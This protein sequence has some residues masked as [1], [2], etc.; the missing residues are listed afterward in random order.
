VLLNRFLEDS[1]AGHPEKTAL[2]CGD[3]RVT[4]AEMNVMAN[5]LA[6]AFRALGLARQDRVCIYHDNS[7]EA[8]MGIFATLKAA[9]IF[10]VVN[11]EVKGDKLSYILNDSGARILV[12]G[13]RN[14]SGVEGD[15]ARTSNLEHIIVAD[16]DCR[17]NLEDSFA[18]V[19]KAG[20]S[21][22]S[23]ADL[24]EAHPHTLPLNPNIDL[25]L[26]GLIYTSGS[27]GQPKGVTLTHLNMVTAATSITTCLHNVYDDVVLSCLP[28]AFNYGLYQVLMAF[29]YGGT[30][31]LERKFLYPGRYMELIAREGA[32]GLPIVPTMLAILLNM[33]NLQQKDFST[34]RYVTNTAQALPVQHIRRMRELMPEARIYSMYGLTECKRVSYLPPALID[35]KPTSVGIAIP[36][37]EVWIE[38]EN[39]NRITTAWQPGE[40]MVRGSHVMVEYWNKPEETSVRLRSGRNPWER[41][42]KTG[43]LF[44]QDEEG[45]LYFISR[46]DDVIKSAGKRVAPQEIERV[47]YELEAVREAAVI[48]VPDEIL[49]NAIKVFV[50]LHDGTTLTASEVIEHC[51]NRLERVMVPKYVEF[52]PELPKTDT[53]KI[54]TRALL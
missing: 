10:L 38:D 37:S 42:L 39:G 1:A 12:T 49:G 41:V 15:L 40:L 7:P 51:Q 6:H 33:K 5:A 46:K 31:I 11:P 32:T 2:V 3:R 17:E 16:A 20:K 13:H 18:L 14:L 9:G 21:V 19:R 8:V 36:N 44:Q 43:D 27:A 53:G 35:S 22:H 23:L 47:L 26:A 50:A 45:H 24:L 28:L 29:K 52:R 48:G 25:D 4:Y 34:V 54:R 30:V